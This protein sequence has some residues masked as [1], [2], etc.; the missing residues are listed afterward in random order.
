[1]YRPEPLPL[2]IW[3]VNPFD[4]IPGEGLPPLRYWS[5][6]RILAGRGH[7]VVWW[8]ADWSHRRKAARTPPRSIEEEEGFAVRLV[9][10]RP[11][12]KNVSFG[13]LLSHRDFGR[14]FERIAS[15]LVASGKLD[16][17]D[18]IL[19]SLPP[20]EGPEAA[21]RLARRLDATLLVD[22][23]DVWPDT[24][25]RLLPGPDWLR[26]T[27]YPLFLGR[28]T[29]R[30]RAILDAADA[31]SG[32]AETY[33]TR[34]P[35][36]AAGDRPRHVCHLGAWVA[37]FPPPPRLIDH[38]PAA[39]EEDGAAEAPRPT[40]PLACVYSGSLEAGQD[41]DALLAAVR[42]LSAESVR[43]TIH[44]AG[45]GRLEPAL[46]AAAESA[47]GSCRIEMHG[48]LGRRDYVRLLSQCDVGL[49]LV[50]P[51]SLVA[52]PYKA[53][54]Y[55]AAGLALVN[56]L[57][58]ELEGLV[59]RYRAGV[60]YTAGRGDSLAAAIAGLA[61]DERRL[62]ELRQGA[63]R[64]AEAEFDRE[65]TYA[66]FADWLEGLPLE[67]AANRSSEPGSP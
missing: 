45:T 40:R 32:C 64:L 66:R 57:P 26:R 23:M 47:R 55:A 9:A 52:L 31:I 48:L 15:E 3:I 20:L 1:M 13:R 16:R 49:V 37:E 22:L 33:F 61:R 34:I 62:L 59:E 30:R 7:E 27:L 28:L 44:V 11:Y 65:K 14:S 6:A 35:E 51:E 58:G 67:T 56:A 10:V 8:S 25:A 63:R 5:L 21:V 24:F 18:V 50:K 36:A 38:V 17:P 39:E 42:Q 41:L 2:S 12:Q 19:A 29:A 54:D 53:C 43:A 4:D 46:R 60:S